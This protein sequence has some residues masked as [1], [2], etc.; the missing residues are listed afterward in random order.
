MLRAVE[1]ARGHGVRI[2]ARSTFSDEI[3]TWVQE[4]DEGDEPA[5]RAVTHSSDDVLFTVRGLVEGT[6]TSSAI[7][8]TVASEHVNVDTI[9]LSAE[10]GNV[11][12]AFSVSADD[13]Q[14]TR[15]ALEQ[16]KQRLGPMDVHQAADLGKVSVVGAG[17]RSHPGV[18]A[19]TFRALEEHGVGVRMISTSPIKI[20]C[21]VDRGDVERGVRALHEAFLLSTAVARPPAAG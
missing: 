7:L 8:R 19:R 10:E 17:I 11:E 1:L 16:A 4:S 12:L 5:V 21:L 3:G 20:S 18:A 15:Q 9:V 14:A 13:V 2:H 6:G